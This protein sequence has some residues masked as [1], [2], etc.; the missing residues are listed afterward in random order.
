MSNPVLTPAEQRKLVQKSKQGWRAFFLMRDN[1]DTLQNWITEINQR[2]YQLRQQLRNNENVDIEY[3]KRQFIEMYDKL[4]E[5][6]ECPV[7]FEVL[8]KDNIEVPNCGHILCKGCREKIKQGDCKCPV[9]RK[10]I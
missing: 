8:T 5:Y 6:T 3:L 1:Y 4:K 9:C 2:N 10:V 7:C